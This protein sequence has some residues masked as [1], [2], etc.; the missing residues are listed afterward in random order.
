MGRNVKEEDINASFVAFA[1]PQDPFYVLQA[2]RL[3]L[4][5]WKAWMNRDFR[6]WGE[7]SGG[8]TYL[9]TATPRR[10]RLE[11]CMKCAEII[12]EEGDFERFT[13]VFEGFRMIFNG[14]VW[15]WKS[16]NDVHWFSQHLDEGTQVG[17]VGPS[18]ARLFWSFPNWHLRHQD[19]LFRSFV[20]SFVS[21]GAGEP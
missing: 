9:K 18:S 16:F 20:G 8:W 11:I 13:R 5:K 15:F 10:R 14:F 4:L 19:F 7:I 1:V 12:W 2:L 6:P 3:R 21:S 17:A